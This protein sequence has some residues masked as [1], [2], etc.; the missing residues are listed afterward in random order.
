MGTIPGTRRPRTIAHLRYF[1]ILFW[2]LLGGK[3]YQKWKI[4]INYTKFYHNFDGSSHNNNN[5]L[6]C[7]YCN[8]WYVWLCVC[9]V[10]AGVNKTLL[11]SVQIGVNYNKR[12]YI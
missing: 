11:N 4:I 7:Y 1:M 9:V 8:K 6:Y 2:L 3:N 12:P 10:V 5:L